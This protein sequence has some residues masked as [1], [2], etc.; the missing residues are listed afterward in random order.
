MTEKKTDT[1]HQHDVPDIAR[2]IGDSHPIEPKTLISYVISQPLA[3]TPGTKTAYS[4]M[5]YLVLGRVVEAA[6]KMPYKNFI[7]RWVALEPVM[8][9]SGIVLD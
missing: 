3:F 9:T 1:P 8:R 7:K 2:H 6:A 5:A 4:N